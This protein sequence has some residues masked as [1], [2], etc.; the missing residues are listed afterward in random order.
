MYIKFATSYQVSFVMHFLIK[1]LNVSNFF[2]ELLHLVARGRRAMAA[3]VHQCFHV[4]CMAAFVGILV[5][6]KMPHMDSTKLH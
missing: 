6:T 2:I 3:A 4:S 5:K 1:A